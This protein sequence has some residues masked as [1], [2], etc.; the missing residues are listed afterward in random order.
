MS[1]KNIQTALGVSLEGENLRVVRVKA[2]GS[3]YKVT[4]LKKY[5]LK[6]LHI[7][8]IAVDVSMSVDNEPIDINDLTGPDT[9]SLSNAS[10]QAG[11]DGNTSAFLEITEMVNPPYCRMGLAITEPLIYYHLI[12]AVGKASHD[13]LIKRVQKE[14][15]ASRENH[16]P[17]EPEAIGIIKMTSDRVLAPIREHEVSLYSEFD[18][19]RPFTQ[20]RIPQITFVETAE[21]ALVNLVLNRHHL[22]SEEI[23]VIIHAGDDRSRFIFLEGWTILHISQAITI[24]DSA[25]DLSSVLYGRLMYEMDSINL[26]R[27]ERVVLCGNAARTSFFEYMRNTFPNTTQVEEIDLQGLGGIEGVPTDSQE[28]APYSVALGS[29]IQALNPRNKEL[30]K[31]DMTPST[32]REKRNKLSLSLV[33]WLL[34]ILLPLSTLGVMWQVSEVKNNVTRLSNEL[35]PKQKVVAEIAMLEDTLVGLRGQL[36]ERERGLAVVDSVRTQISVYSQFVHRTMV[37]TNKIGGIW[38]TDIISGEGQRSPLKDTLSI[39]I[40]CYNFK[41]RCNHR[42]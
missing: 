16:P 2:E 10:T 37:A 11:M 24:T 5:R 36:M 28:L 20:R 38:L 32:I 9:L 42:Y 35:A 31:V 1:N 33:G 17:P 19:V 12:E 13:K 30:I 25:R 6:E 23:T 40:K 15:P 14:F 22:D 7:Q 26:T 41:P 34:L 39:G 8:P 4:A 18:R 3:S 27:L 21:T 29:A